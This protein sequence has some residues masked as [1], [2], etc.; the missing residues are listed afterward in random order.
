MV[1]DIARLAASEIAGRVLAGELLAAD[2]AEAFLLRAEKIG[3]ALNTWIT[4]DREGA[5]NQARIIDEAMAEGKDPGPLAGVPVGLKDI[6][7]VAG[8][9]TTAGS[10]ILKDQVAA[11]DAPLTRKIRKAGAVILGKL[12][13]HEFAF[14]PSGHNPHYGDQKNPWDT[15]RVTGGSSGGS[16]NAAA[17]GQASITIGSDTG[18][19]IR[20][21]TSLCGVIGHKPT[22]GLVTKAGCVSLSWSL[23]SF[24]PMATSARDCALMMSTIAGPDP[25]DPSSLQVE[26]P[27]FIGALDKPLAGLRIGH[28][29]NYYAD[30][31][32]PAV[33]EAIEEVDR[34]LSDAGAQVV[35]VNIP[36]LK[37]AYGAATNFMMPE[38]A[39]YH[40]KNIRERPDDY[41]PKVLERLKIGFFIPAT[42]YIQAQ[43]FRSQWTAQVLKEVF[44]KVDLVLA[45]ATPMPA[46]LRSAKTVT[47]A[48]K[49]YDARG[50][51]IALTR[52]INFLGFPSTGFPA[53]ISDEGLPLGAQLIGPPLHD[54]RTLAAVHQLGKAGAV[55]FQ[56]APFEG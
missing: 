2:V 6:I 27:D 34:A 7:D 3:P 48:G 29:R 43:R 11:G 50:H 19:S 15:K 46:P 53:G 20:I 5:L 17:T 35:E 52:H 8:L 23:D 38:A 10:L 40:E 47:V 14:G 25:E 36:G 22:F 30:Q 26:A 41:D 33:C 21:P 44:G 13:M 1:D 32:D 55:R 18:G 4:L 31:S 16:G 37:T 42:S 12:N 45:A 39:A 56:F 24:G 51:L 9:R 49:E 28:A 54:H